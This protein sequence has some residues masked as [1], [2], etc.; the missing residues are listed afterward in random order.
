MPKLSAE[1]ASGPESSAPTQGPFLMPREQKCSDGPDKGR[2]AANRVETFRWG[3]GGSDSV[4]RVTLPVWDP[5]DHLN[6]LSRTP[7]VRSIRLPRTPV[8]S[9]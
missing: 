4:T 5:E 6:E 9:G 7:E 2:A 8:D 1:E 3:D